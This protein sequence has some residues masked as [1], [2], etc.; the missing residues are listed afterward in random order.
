[1]AS[2]R[3]VDA[4]DNQGRGQEGHKRG[5]LSERVMDVTG[6]GK[7]SRG[8]EAETFGQTDGYERD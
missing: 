4:R 3:R 1:M 7:W 2:D 8:V 6:E 5:M